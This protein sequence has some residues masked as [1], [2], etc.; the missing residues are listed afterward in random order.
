MR[1]GSR[2]TGSSRGSAE[3]RD[4]TAVSGCGLGART[5]IAAPAQGGNDRKAK[6]R[7][8]P[9]PAG[10]PTWRGPQA[11]EDVALPKAPTPWA[12]TTRRPRSTA[13]GETRERRRAAG[14][15]ETV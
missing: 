11:A 4:V 3:P 15:W 1:M 6:A 8:A 7:E 9:S 5:V 14:P 13:T 12:A 10:V 2:V